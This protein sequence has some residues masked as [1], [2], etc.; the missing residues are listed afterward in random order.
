MGENDVEILVGMN[1]A[2]IQ[3]GIGQVQE[4]LARLQAVVQESAVGTSG[5]GAGFASMGEKSKGFFASM[6]E[7]IARAGT[8]MES[9]AGKILSSL[10]PLNLLN[11]GMVKLM[12]VMAGWRL[13]EGGFQAISNFAQGIFQLPIAVEKAQGAWAYMFNPA[14]QAGAN[15]DQWKLQ[16]QAIG[17]GIADWTMKESISLPYTRQDLIAAITSLAPSGLSATGIEHYMPIIADIAAT[18]NPNLSLQQ[19]SYSIMGAMMGYTRMLRYDLHIMPEQLAQYGYDQ[20]NPSTLL[21][22]LEKYS[23]AT[24]GTQ[25][26]GGQDVGAAYQFSHT[27]FWGEWSSFIDRIQNSQLMTGD[28]GPFKSLKQGL[29]WVN[30]FMDS[31]SDQIGAL[32][33]LIGTDLSDAMQ[34]GGHAFMAFAQGLAGTGVG[35]NIEQMLQNLGKFLSD[36]KNIQNFDNLAKTLGTDLGDLATHAGNAASGIQSFLNAVGPGP[37]GLL[38]AFS[39]LLGG[40]LDQVGRLGRVLGDLAKEFQDIKSGNWK[41]AEMDAVQFAADSISYATGGQAKINVGLTQA[42]L[43]PTQFTAAQERDRHIV[44]EDLMA[45]YAQQHPDMTAAERARMIRAR[46][47]GYFGDFPGPLDQ[48]QMGS[49]GQNYAALISTSMFQG[50]K[51]L[52]PQFAQHGDDLMTEIT[53]AVDRK[54]GEIANA[55]TSAI[56]TGIQQVSGSSYSASLRQAGKAS[57]FGQTG[58]IFG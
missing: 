34:A 1:A 31:H 25:W 8:S 32:A 30:N 40:M 13:M 48:S 12:E 36:P 10:N 39:K 45:Q 16:G 56:L 35:T 57:V 4:G 46:Q 28:Y 17:K 37:L 33:K 24:G 21:P 18:R 54:K 15:L 26:K 5:V 22:A 44:F 9:F 49:T 41:Q 47:G 14:P 29:E 38:D 23:I 7:G 42:I 43:N 58:S 19:A 51:S 11:S 52:M 53:K 55:I 20:G 50:F 2:G 27:T 6:D 3:V